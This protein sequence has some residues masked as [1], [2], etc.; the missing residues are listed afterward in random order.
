MLTG[1]RI[2]VASE[3]G[4]GS[5]GAGLVHGLRREGW[6]VEE[7]DP[8][9]F[10]MQSNAYVSRA[11]ARLMK[12]WSQADLN[13]AILLAA[14]CV[15][16]QAFLTVKGSLIAAA[17]LR[18]LK[19]YGIAT[20]MYYPDY[21][22]GYA[23]VD[24]STF[25]RYDLFF[26]TKSFQLPWLCERLG[27]DR[28]CLVHHGYCDQV[29]RA[30][31][32][33]VDEQAYLADVVYVGNYAPSKEY[34]LGAI[35]RRLPQVD[36]RIVGSRW[37]VARDVAVKARAIGHVID[38]D[39]YARAIEHSRINLAVHGPVA[40]APD[41]QDLVSTRTFEIP[42]CKGFMLHIDN[43]EVRTLFQPG[44]EIDVFSNPDELVAKIEH[45]L[46]RP[47][48]RREMIT[49]AYA[50]A[51]PAYG[52]DARASEISCRIDELLASRSPRRVT[53]AV[54]NPSGPSA[55]ADAM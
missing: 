32:A 11:L 14:Q 24:Q 5:T 49:R 51:V 4:V 19:A 38:G 6:A 33:A 34:W 22:F 9:L 26:T 54:L 15:E 16:P 47:E 7:I 48:L 46:A 53:A 43:A 30:G 21:H 29:H 45:Y 13:N 37:D 39:L 28:V 35:V 36:L 44:R 42:A 40:P 27:A 52:Y 25:E 31:K 12:P 8:R 1:K 20:V 2:I 10:H 23:G 3:M 41:W 18:H 55:R 17:T 50:R